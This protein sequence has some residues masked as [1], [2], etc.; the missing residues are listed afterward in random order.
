MKKGKYDRN[1]VYYFIIRNCI[2]FT[3]NMYRRSISSL[4]LWIIEVYKIFN[5]YALKRRKCPTT[6]FIFPTTIKSR[7]Y[8]CE[9]LCIFYQRDLKFDTEREK[10]RVV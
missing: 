2:L 1:D 4:S 9:I 5:V 10:K 3:N 6:N 8:S 7:L